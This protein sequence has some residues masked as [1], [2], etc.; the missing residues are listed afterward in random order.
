[1]VAATTGWQDLTAHFLAMSY[2]ATFGMTP[3][4]PLRN[5][6]SSIVIIILK[7]KINHLKHSRSFNK[8]SAAI[9][10]IIYAIVDTDLLLK[11]RAAP[12]FA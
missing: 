10:I 2:L 3:D 12:P 6:I 8:A 4:S 9:D 11:S 7:H 1:M 5:N